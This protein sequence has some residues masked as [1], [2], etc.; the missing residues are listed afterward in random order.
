MY[1]NPH[2]GSNTWPASH[3]TPSEDNSYAQDRSEGDWGF[4]TS[5]EFDAEEGAY[6]VPPTHAESHGSQQYHQQSHQAPE[7]RAYQDINPGFDRAELPTQD[8]PRGYHASADPVT[9]TETSSSA[10]LNSESYDQVE[11][12]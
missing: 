11:N 4:V 5:S 9:G 2:R 6:M 12:M 7:D 8:Y 10:I 1:N 3:G